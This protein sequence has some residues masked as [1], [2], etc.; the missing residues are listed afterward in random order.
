MWLL[1]FGKRGSLFGESERGNWCRAC[2]EKM[3]FL[4]T[5]TTCVLFSNFSKSSSCLWSLITFDSSQTT[6]AKRKNTEQHPPQKAP[7]NHA[8]SMVFTP[9][10]SIPGRWSRII[11][12]K[13]IKS[14]YSSCALKAL[15]WMEMGWSWVFWAFFVFFSNF[16]GLLVNQFSS[17][18]FGSFF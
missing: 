6:Q 11:A 16:F 14:S 1:P 12:L 7:K 15:R 13:R 2:P 10:F 4:A 5:T 9:T 8:S 3:Q 17:F 18:C